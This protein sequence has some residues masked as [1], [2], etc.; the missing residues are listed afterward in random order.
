MI[1]A[2]GIKL[3]HEIKYKNV[4]DLLQYGVVLLFVFLKC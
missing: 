3:Y 1:F 2:I 4:S